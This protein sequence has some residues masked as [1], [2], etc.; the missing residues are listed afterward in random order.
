LTNQLQFD[1]IRVS[2]VA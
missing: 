1:N 2:W